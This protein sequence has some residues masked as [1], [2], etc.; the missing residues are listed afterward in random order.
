ML[1]PGAGRRWILSE[2]SVAPHD[3]SQAQIRTVVFCA[4]PRSAA[5]SDEPLYNVT[6]LRQP[7]EPG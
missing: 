6:F 2:R 7:C 3:V 4:V 1:L 5:A